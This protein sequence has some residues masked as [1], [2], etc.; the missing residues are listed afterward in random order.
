MSP[1]QTVFTSMHHQRS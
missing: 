1:F